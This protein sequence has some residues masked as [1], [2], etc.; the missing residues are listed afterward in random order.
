[1]A[2]TKRVYFVNP[3]SGNI[4]AW[5]APSPGHK[6][7]KYVLSGCGQ[8]ALQFL[9]ETAGNRNIDFREMTAQQIKLTEKGEQRREKMLEKSAKAI[10]ESEK[11]G[12]KAKKEKVEK[13]EP[14]EEEPEAK[15]AKE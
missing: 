9:Y 1:M 8:K 3:T 2:S 10:A 12:A 13:E 6:D 7:G 4:T 15:G 5:A 14:K 11:K